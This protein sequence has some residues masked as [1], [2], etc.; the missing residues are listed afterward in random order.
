MFL[1]QTLILTS[2][3]SKGQSLIALKLWCSLCSEWLLGRA[4]LPQASC[5]ILT[6]TGLRPHKTIAKLQYYYPLNSKGRGGAACWDGDTQQ[7]G[8][9]AKGR[10]LSCA[11]A[12][13]M[14]LEGALWGTLTGHCPRSWPGTAHRGPGV[15]HSTPVCTQQ[16]HVHRARPGPQGQPSSPTSKKG[17]TLKLSSQ[18][19]EPF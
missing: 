7:G 13:A 3:V 6:G 9:S 18:E 12:A 16:H 15:P 14:G 10:E 1:T 5:F 8:L 19:S 11:P 17:V 2:D 4:A